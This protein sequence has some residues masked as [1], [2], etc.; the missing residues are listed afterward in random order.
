MTKHLDCCII[1]VIKTHWPI[2]QMITWMQVRAS[3]SFVSKHVS[4]NY[5]EL[6]IHVLNGSIITSILGS[7]IQ[8]KGFW[9]VNLAHT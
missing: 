3:K 9:T 2:D 6:L 4:R 1:Q 5:Q 8:G 7:A